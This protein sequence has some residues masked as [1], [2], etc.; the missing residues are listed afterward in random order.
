M[1][2]GGLAGG[3]LFMG[4]ISWPGRGPPDMNPTFKIFRFSAQTGGNG[5]WRCLLA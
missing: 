5:P 1:I 4:G 2:G 3:R